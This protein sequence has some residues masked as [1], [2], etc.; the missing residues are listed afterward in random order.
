[1][2]FKGVEPSNPHVSL[3]LSQRPPSLKNEG[4]RRSRMRKSVKGRK[5]STRKRP[6]SR[7]RRRRSEGLLRSL[8][9]ATDSA[10][11][12][13]LQDACTRCTEATRQRHR[14]MNIKRGRTLK[15]ESVCV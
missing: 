3:T 15:A 8:S 6:A 11:E 2:L 14:N 7:R 4:F 12:F 9:P 10:V 5:P 13:I 1:M